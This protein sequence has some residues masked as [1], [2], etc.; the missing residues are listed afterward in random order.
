MLGDGQHKQHAELQGGGRQGGSTAGCPWG[1]NRLFL[2]HQQAA[3]SGLWGSDRHAMSS[4]SPHAPAPARPV[5]GC[6]APAPSH[7]ARCGAGR[8]SSLRTLPT[9]ACLP[10]GLAPQHHL[11]ALPLPLLPPAGAGTSPAAQPQSR[12]AARAWCC[13]WWQLLQVQWERRWD[14]AAGS[15]AAEGQQGR[16]R[17][18]RSSRVRKPA[19]CGSIWTCVHPRGIGGGTQDQ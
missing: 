17:R 12:P 19:D 16:E 7:P 2:V 11:P 9:R 3:V 6:R 13:R 5:K 4:C 14:L 15:L 8:Q 10:A 1:S 18:R